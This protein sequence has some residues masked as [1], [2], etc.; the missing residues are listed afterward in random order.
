MSFIDQ[1]K[2]RAS[3]KKLESEFHQ[4]LDPS[5][6]INNPF[7]VSMDFENDRFQ[8]QAHEKE[9]FYVLLFSRLSLSFEKGFLL[10]AKSELSSSPWTC[11]LHFSE[12]QLS[13]LETSIPTEFPVPSPGPHKVV[14][15]N[16]SQWDLKTKEWR[17]LL[18]QTPEWTAL[19]FEV[20]PGIR[21]LFCT[22]LAE[23][24]LQTQ[25]E[26]THQFIERALTYQP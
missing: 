18:P 3:F 12:G 22:R 21:F 25:T 19:L 24:W 9:E 26:N 23:P 17:Y 6:E 20:G 5:K 11:A 1:E 7:E 10:E 14:R 4:I 8:I 15:A 13:V 2:I 16:P